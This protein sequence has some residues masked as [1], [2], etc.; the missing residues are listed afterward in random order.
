MVAKMKKFMQRI[1]LI[2]RIFTLR[3][4]MKRKEPFPWLIKEKQE[5]IDPVKAARG[6][7]MLI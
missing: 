2:Q 7:L 5:T 4:V 3:V 1:I 6:L